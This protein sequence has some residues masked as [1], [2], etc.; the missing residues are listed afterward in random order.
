MAPRDRML[1]QGWCPHQ[2][3]YLARVFNSET[4]LFV[5]RLSRQRP[6]DHRNCLSTTS[7]VAYNAD[8][9]NYRTKH[10]SD[11]CGCNLAVVPYEQIIDILRTGE[12]PLIS[13]S[14]QG[15]GVDIQVTK[16]VPTSQYVA[17]S[18]VWADG[19]GNPHLNA[20]PTCQLKKLTTSFIGTWHQSTEVNLTTPCSYWRLRTTRLTTL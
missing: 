12:V 14:P 11:N 10:I 15:D 16:R 4:F 18:H 19:L 9:D 13:V 17:I 5:S 6:G 2:I 1:K 20:L 7:C 3:S 8:M